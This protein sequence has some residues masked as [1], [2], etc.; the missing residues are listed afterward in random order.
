M[1]W[2]CRIFYNPISPEFLSPKRFNIRLCQNHSPFK[3][4]KIMKSKILLSLIGSLL[5]YVNSYAAET[6][7]NN[8]VAQA[9][10]LTLNGSN[11]GKITTAGDI[12][13]FRVTTTS[14]G[15]LNVTLGKSSAKAIAVSIYDNNGTTLLNSAS[16]TASFTQSKDGLAAGTYYIKVQC[17]AAADTASYSISNTVTAVTQVNDVE[18]NDTRA[19]A[20]TFAP[21]TTKTG[22]A[23][24][25]YNNKRD[26]S[27]WY[28]ITTTGDGLLKLTLTPAAATSIYMALYDNNG[29]TILDSSHGTAAFSLIRDGLATGT[30]YI[31]VRCAVSSA[32]VPYTFVNTFTAPAQA[33]DV[34]PND[35]RITATVMALNTTKTGHAGFYYNNKRDTSDW[36]KITTTTDRKLKL[37]LT[38][39]N[40]HSLSLSLYA[41]NGT[42]LIGRSTGTGAFS[43]TTD[44][45]KADIY[46]VKINAV[47]T[48][49]FAPYTFADS[50][51]APTTD[52]FLLPL[53]FRYRNRI[54]TPG[55]ANWW[56][57][58]TNADGKLNLNLTPLTS[59]YV[60]LYLY[61]RDRTTLL[62]SSYSNGAFSQSTDGLAPGTYYLKV[63]PYYATDSL[64]YTI[65]DTLVTPA[66][67]VETE[68]NDSRAQALALTLNSTKTGHIGYY[69]NNKRDTSDWYRLTTNADG[70]LDMTLTPA[71]GSYVY[72]TLYDNNGT[73][74]LKSTY[75]NATF[76][77]ST[78]GLAAGTYYVKVN[79]YYTNGF[80]PYT[81][82]NTLVTPAQANDTE[83]ND[84]RATALS[85]SVNTTRTGHS[86][87]YYNNKRDTADWYRVTTSSDG[88]VKLKLTPANGSYIYVSLYDNNGTTVLN[89]S[90]SNAAFVQNT[91]GLAA[92][93]Y[94][95]KV[96]C[97]YNNQFT[98]YTLTDSLYT[99]SFANDAEPNKRPFQGAAVTANSTVTGHSNFYYNLVK[100]S[101]DWRKLNYTGSG[102]LQFTFNLATKKIDGSIPYTYFIVYKDTLAAPVYSNYF[103]TA[104]NVISLSSLTKTTYYIKIQTY[105]LSDFVAYSFSNLFTAARGLKEPVSIL[106]ANDISI[107]PNPVSSRL[108]V[109]VN[110]KDDKVTSVTLRDANGRAVWSQSN[111][112]II[113]GGVLDV[114]VSKYPPGIY[115]LHMNDANGKLI[116][117]KI[118]IEK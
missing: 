67:A 93:T 9:N 98:P 41:N 22:H 80:T 18:P 31:K 88:M 57:L 46:Y 94:Y 65:A 101:A 6:E 116:I 87:Y 95:V 23:G 19:L 96:N 43:L 24:Y 66:Q 7:P 106:P 8:T 53:N 34:E 105:Y 81:L 38:P 11:T 71:N 74:V 77:Q 89:Q 32:F 82:T 35:A 84:T 51:F 90:Y 45:L 29:T 108:H 33:T 54:A 3:K 85:L 102:N 104:S 58:T 48:S 56:R 5:L 25:Y 10:I 21:N 59:K 27:D 91:D 50:I 113:K 15:R 30:Y 92:G 60:W 70:R 111:T 63:L 36:Y 72:V 73:I 42:S 99:Y 100:D 114:D 118:V 64:S 1:R 20:L 28:K 103:N 39:A 75:S 4:N 16:S 97:Y 13:F 107:Y 79:C 37:N 47:T 40:G 76:N 62:N 117:K 112:T 110:G 69:Y 83:P 115:F 2:K 52:S 26:T 49:D 68:P 55:A 44:G 14:D 12:D 86:G 78:D 109:Q 61:D 17:V